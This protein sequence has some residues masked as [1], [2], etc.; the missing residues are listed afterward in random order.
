MIGSDQDQVPANKAHTIQGTG[1]G[2][3]LTKEI[4]ET[5][6]GNIAVESAEGKGTKATVSLPMQA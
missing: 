3:S 2:L 4:L 6:G 1:I 5:H